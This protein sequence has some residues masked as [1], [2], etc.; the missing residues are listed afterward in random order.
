M[1]GS[2]FDVS[3][4][5]FELSL[6]FAL[7]PDASFEVVERLTAS[8]NSFTC[9]GELAPA[10]AGAGFAFLAV[11]VG[12][13]LISCHLSTYLLSKPV[14]IGRLRRAGGMGRQ[15]PLRETPSIKAVQAEV[16]STLCVVWISLPFGIPATCPSTP[17]LAPFQ[18]PFVFCGR[19]SVKRGC[20]FNLQHRLA[21]DHKSK[22]R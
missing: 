4:E 13:M 15:S 9:F 16:A 3:C 5:C 10:F 1:M 19:R 22:M 6:P 7:M 14:A 18:K 17:H 8:L 2:D 12:G 20:R 11:P 21:H